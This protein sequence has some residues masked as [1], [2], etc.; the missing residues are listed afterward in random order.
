MEHSLSAHRACRRSG[1]GKKDPQQAQDCCPPVRCCSSSPVRLRLFI[2]RAARWRLDRPYA[3]RREWGERSR[4]AAKDAVR[5]QPRRRRSCSMSK[6]L[7]AE[8][9]MVALDRDHPTPL[10]VTTLWR[11]SVLPT[12]QTRQRGRG[13][14]SCDVERVAFDRTTFLGSTVKRRPPISRLDSGPRPEASP[15]RS[16]RSGCRFRPTIFPG[17]GS[18]VSPSTRHWPS[19]SRGASE[20]AR[21][22]NQ[23]STDDDCATRSR[24]SRPR[25]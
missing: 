25:N 4:M 10:S 19:L 23:V 9:L 15:F 16:P 18:V 11:P 2:R 8:G 17:T 3:T 21:D 22:R 5:F 13:F 12:P 14:Y 24:P 6:T 7:R 1:F 20:D